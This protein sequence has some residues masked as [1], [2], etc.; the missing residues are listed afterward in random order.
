MDYPISIKLALR[1]VCRNQIRTLITL[2]AIAFGSVSII[3]A[4]GFFEDTFLRMREAAIHSHL[5]HIQIYFEGYNDHVAS[6]PFASI[7]LS[8]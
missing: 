7:F 1:N 3:I 6:A 8:L 2:A 4:G 5:G